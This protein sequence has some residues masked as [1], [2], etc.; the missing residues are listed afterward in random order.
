M[1]NTNT[2]A[3][4]N[5]AQRTNN[6]NSGE[7]AGPIPVYEMAMDDLA[8][9]AGANIDAEDLLGL[10]GTVEVRIPEVV[11]AV[12]VGVIERTLPETH[13][14]VRWYP[15]EV[16]MHGHPSDYAAVART[17][18]DAEGDTVVLTADQLTTLC[19]V[20]VTHRF[21]VA[22]RAPSKWQYVNSTVRKAQYALLRAERGRL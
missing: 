1:K 16:P 9:P 14:T 20:D 19:D 21:D 17:L 3:A 11:R 5:G 18:R 12:A 22:E 15:D 13:K 6:P 8:Y 7:H 2:K 10:S 4:N